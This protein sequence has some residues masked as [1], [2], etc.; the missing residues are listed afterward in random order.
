MERKIHALVECHH[1]ERGKQCQIERARIGRHGPDPPDEPYARGNREPA[2]EREPREPGLARQL[3]II[4]VRLAEISA[5]VG[6][7]AIA[8][9]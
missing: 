8:R 7:P 5:R 1:G 3:D 9:K 6:R 4:I 2:D